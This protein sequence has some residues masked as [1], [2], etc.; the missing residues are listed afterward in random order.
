MK[1]PIIFYDGYCNLCTSLVKRV[2]LQDRRKIFRYAPLNSPVGAVTLGRLKAE[3]GKVPDSIILLHNERL[4]LKSAA[5]LRI[6]GMLGGVW[7]LLVVFWIVPKPIRDW[8]YDL[9][10]RKRYRWF[11][12]RKEC[13]LPTEDLYGNQI[14]KAPPPLPRS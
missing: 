5:V 12:K 14:L 3:F 9:V 10:A 1:Q 4:Y 2:L 6:A 13:Y 11:G 7:Y 8:V